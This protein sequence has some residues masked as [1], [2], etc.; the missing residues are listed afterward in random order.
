MVGISLMSCKVQKSMEFET[1]IEESR[2]R[3]SICRMMRSIDGD[4]RGGM[5]V[6][7]GWRGEKEREGGGVEC[8]HRRPAAAIN[9]PT[10]VTKAPPPP[11]HNHLA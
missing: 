9:Q 3:E 1:K 4:G 6:M 2:K 10:C 8:F 5:G 11:S 7:E